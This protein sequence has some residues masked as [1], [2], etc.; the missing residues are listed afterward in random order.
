MHSRRDRYITDA[1]LL[2]LTALLVLT[3]AIPGL[4]AARPVLALVGCCVLPGAA[5]LTL[6]PVRDFLTWALLA[7]LMSLAVL[8][9][10][11]LVT[12][13]AGLWEPL[14]LA[15]V[16]GAASVFLLGRDLRGVIRTPRTRTA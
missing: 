5:L 9:L 11:S 6:I 2:A 10:T 16:L 15:G 7:V 8:T 3:I 13:W 4:G 14:V 12:L 1:G